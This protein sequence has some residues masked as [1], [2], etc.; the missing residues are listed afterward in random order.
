M[1][2][3]SAFKN[4]NKILDKEYKLIKSLPIYLVKN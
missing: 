2:S 1:F 4:L 3:D